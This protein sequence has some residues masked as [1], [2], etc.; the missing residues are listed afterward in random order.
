MKS[1]NVLNYYEILEIRANAS[2]LE[3]RQ[4]YKDTL[5]IYNEDSPVTYS[6]F[7]DNERDKILKT[8]G[9][10]FSTLIDR[11]SRVEYDS[12]LVRS[13]KVKKSDLIKT[14]KQKL[15]SIFG[16]R[17]SAGDNAFNRKVK[18]KAKYR[19]AKE[20]SDQIISKELI[21]GKDLKRLR[22]AMSIELEEVYE[23]TR[24]SV[25]ILK[26]IEENN[27]EGLPSGIYLQNFL[28][29][30]ADFFK[31]DSKKIINGYLKNLK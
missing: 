9:K 30:Y 28:K 20:I 26:S 16:D 15:I 3:I 12:V 7:S 19:E 22:Q 11:K 17:S 10:A 14:D 29:I 27:A 5:S 8:I 31:I 18:E 13:G 24:I 25:S 1:F 4:A 6:M 23:V 21:S 2:D